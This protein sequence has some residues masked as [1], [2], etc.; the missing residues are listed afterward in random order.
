MSDSLVILAY[1]RPNRFQVQQDTKRELKK[2]N[3][4]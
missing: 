3:E 4:K 1:F 2:N